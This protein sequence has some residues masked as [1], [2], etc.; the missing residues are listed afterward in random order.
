MNYT[1]EKNPS[2]L[3]LKSLILNKQKKKFYLQSLGQSRNI[4]LKPKFSI[5]TS[6]LKTNNSNIFIKK[7]PSKTILTSSK[8]NYNTLNNNSQNKKFDIYKR[9]NN[10]KIKNIESSKNK[11]Y[12]KSSIKKII[13]KKICKKNNKKKLMQNITTK[14]VNYKFNTINSDNNISSKDNNIILNNYE[15]YYQIVNKDNNN[16]R[17][18]NNNSI[19]N[20]VIQDKNKNKIIHKEKKIVGIMLKK[21]S[22]LIDNLIT[23]FNKKNNNY[24]LYENNLG[25]NISR[26]N[27][28]KTN[29]S[30]SSLLLKKNKISHSNKLLNKNKINNRNNNNKNIN[31][32]MIK[33]DI[34]IDYYND[35]SKKNLNTIIC[36]CNNS[37]TYLTNIPHLNRITIN[38]YNYKIKK[39]LKLNLVE[40]SKK[41]H[42][43]D[44]NNYNFNTRNANTINIT[45][46]NSVNNIYDN[47]ININKN[48]KITYIKVNSNSNNNNKLDN[49]K[50]KK[51]S[52]IL[53]PRK[54]V[55]TKN[56]SMNHSYQNII[57]NY[58]K[59]FKTKEKKNKKI[60]QKIKENLKK[61][62][63]KKKKK[64][65]ISLNNLHLSKV[66]LIGIQDIFSNFTL[67]KKKT[68][69]FDTPNINNTFD[70]FNMINFSGRLNRTEEKSIEFFTSMSEKYKNKK[71]KFKEDP[72]Y[73]YEYFYEILNNLLIEENNY[74]EKL[75]LDQINLTKKKYHINPDSRSF[76]INSLI[77][78]QELLNFTE[79]TLFLTTQ[80][81]DRYISN[82]LMKKEITIKEE[83]LDIVIVTSLIIAAK[84]EEIKLYS[85]NDYLNLL[86][87]KYNIHDLEKTEYEILSGFD[88]NLDIPSMLDFYEIFSVENKLNKFQQAKG[89]YLLNFILLDSNLVQIPSS[90]IAYAV[91][92]VVSGKNIPL[93]KLS[94]YHVNNSEKKIFKLLD[95]LKDREIINNL[96]VYIKYLYKIKKNSSYNAPFNKFNTPNYYFISSYFDI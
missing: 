30:E 4:S 16:I 83:N 54:F 28:F 1:K 81:F 51:N 56:D 12:Q 63:E 95:I 79:R 42:I 19:N 41:M 75:D 17:K 76:F 66:K 29:S 69:K 31:T 23:T 84:K 53:F 14:N 68:P 13:T 78:I 59:R 21:K 15:Q 9:I 20:N 80:I 34:I 90:L 8:S 58:Q 27:A 10:S 40:N 6:I 57:I 47:A 82:V 22:A 37:T 45:I 48:P 89:L 26:K 36:N 85:M 73:V 96:C 71:S 50:S 55:F 24:N 18:N 11:S 64:Q 39:P 72:Q 91:I 33:N 94:E 5:N 67:I 44:N 7:F 25:N 46:D 3:A 61:I 65:M 62:H 93:N 38:N 43:L 35:R 70:N 87:L 86:P 74:F 60:G 77:N 92:S 32:N 88:F 2:N 52:S 49:S